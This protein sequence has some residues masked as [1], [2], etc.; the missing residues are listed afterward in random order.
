ML[1]THEEAFVR[2][3]LPSQRRER[4]LSAL[5]EPR[6]RNVFFR[7]PHHPPDGFIIEKFI[8]PIKPS[9]QYTP[10]IAASLKKL[11]AGPSCWVF[12]NKLD[13]Q[14]M[15]LEEAL[16]SLIGSRSGTIASCIPGKLAYVE[17]EED[18]FIL[19]AS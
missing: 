14:Q 16:Q 12:G 15:P 13:G 3:F 2:T 10:M 1:N 4:F 7:H 18:R 5:E 11:G 9:E 17:S 8:V 19:Y 6:R